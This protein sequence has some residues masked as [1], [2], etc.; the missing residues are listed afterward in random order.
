MSTSKNS[1]TRVPE[2][3]KP[4]DQ[5]REVYRHLDHVDHG[6]LH[7]AYYGQLR[8][9]EFDHDTALE[10]T[11][12]NFGLRD[13]TWYQ[14]RTGMRSWEDDQ[15]ANPTPITLEDGSVVLPR[16]AVVQARKRAAERAGA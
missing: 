1:V 3:P 15:R 2:R 12:E 9:Q 11:V 16:P 14:Y 13:E 7:I 10:M 5:L 4:K 6:N 8:A